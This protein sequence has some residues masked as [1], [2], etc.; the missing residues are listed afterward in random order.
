MILFFSSLRS[1]ESKFLLLAEIPLVSLHFS[2]AQSAF[3]LSVLGALGSR[4]GQQKR[5][6][7]HSAQYFSPSP[8]KQI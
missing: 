5:E 3:G 1:H 4:W 6:L 8:V 7:F 2:D